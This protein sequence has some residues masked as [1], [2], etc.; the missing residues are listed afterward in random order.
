MKQIVE[1]FNKIGMLYKILASIA[2]GIG[3]GFLGIEWLIRIFITFNSIFLELLKFSVP[4]VIFAFITSSII[5]FGDSSKKIIGF[6][7]VSSLISSMSVGILCLL[8][9]VAIFPNILSPTNFIDSQKLMQLQPYFKISIP[10]FFSATSIMI[11]SFVVGVGIIYSKSDTL[12]K[13]V[14]EFKPIVHSFLAKAIIP[15]L[16]LYVLGS[17]SNMAYT[18]QS[19]AIL[20]EF[21]KAIAICYVVQILVIIIYYIAAAIISKQNPVALLKTMLPAYFTAVAAGSSTVAMPVTMECMKKLGVRAS[22]AEF[23]TPLCAN[24]HMPGSMIHI[25]TYATAIMVMFG[26]TMLPL[27][28]MI[29]FVVVLSFMSI[30]APGIPGGIKITSVA[31]LE[32]MLGFNEPMI[33]LVMAL[34]VLGTSTG[35]NVIADGAL[36]I[37]L[38]KRF[39][40]VNRK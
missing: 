10:A 11:F 23:I 18:N 38:E 25:T 16:P 7:S 8:I 3:L 30:A 5:E 20:F 1:S 34:P 29:I 17:F 19:S 32:S 40:R 6:V 33:A 35:C 37:L 14:K 36:A 28:S 9:V 15:F 2:L 12:A 22:V 13:G 26:Q 39:N 31:I 4:L 24:I 27:P 21:I